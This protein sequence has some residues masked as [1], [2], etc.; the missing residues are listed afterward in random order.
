MEDKKKFNIVITDNETGEKK[1]YDTC[2]FIGALCEDDGVTTLNRLSCGAEKLVHTIAAL[3]E[4]IEH[5]RREH[6][7]LVL[8]QFLMETHDEADEAQEDK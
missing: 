6:P 5:L 1:E 2:A 4:R 8:L 7:E 3:E